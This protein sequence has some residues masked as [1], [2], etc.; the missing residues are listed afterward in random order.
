MKRLNAILLTMALILTM[1]PSTV[2][3]AAADTSGDYTYQV[4]NGVATIT[5]YNGTGGNVTIPASLGGYPVRTIGTGAFASCAGLTSVTI[6]SGVTALGD[7]A[8]RRCGSLRTV[9][10]GSGVATIGVGAFQDC[11]AMT[12]VTIPAGVSA[13]GDFA[14]WRCTSLK[15][16]ALPETLQTIGEAAFDEC[17]SLTTLT[18]PAV[19]SFG[20]YAFGTCTALKEVTFGDGVRAIGNMAFMECGALKK[21]TFLGRA[22][23]F[24]EECFRGVTAT[25]AY[26]GADVTWVSGIMQQYG[27]KITW[28]GI[29]IEQRMWGKTRTETAVAISKAAFPEGADN[30]ILASGD[31]YPDA[32]AGGPLAYALN[33]PILLVCRSNPDQAT[34]SEI[35]RL[36]AKNAYILG[37]TGVIKDSVADTLS[38]MGLSVERL[39]GKDRF[40]TAVAIAE[41]LETLRGAKPDEVFFV[42]FNN[43]PDALA[44]SNV[45]ALKGSPILYIEGNGVLQ[46]SITSYMD[47]LTSVSKSYILGGPAVVNARADASLGAYGTV[48]RI[49]GSDRYETCTKINRKFSGILNG[50]S[51]C[52][53]CGTN[54][55]DALAGSVFAAK[56]HAPLLLAGSSLSNDQTSYIKTKAPRFVYAFGGTGVLSDKVLQAVKQAAV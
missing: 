47:G 56:H 4:S 23:A 33:A 34:L 26:P 14:F 51:L 37:G 31:N 41:K 7:D 18:I 52:L 49:Y 46:S 35:R 11:A 39:A 44:V 9:T 5:K 27:G 28:Q 40:R 45:A 55:P 6:P 13:I 29:G 25:A 43:Y 36:G 20:D 1:L 24:G 2:L 42:F 10:I 8:F 12:S 22:P 17:T 16:L 38:N 3:M 50:D 19:S 21:I 15:I 53:A 30:V 32:L 54:Y 48:E